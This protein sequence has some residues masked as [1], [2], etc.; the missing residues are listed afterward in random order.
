MERNI[1]AQWADKLAERITLRMVEAHYDNSLT[2]PDL[3]RAAFINK[4]ALGQI[5]T[6][7]EA[8]R[9]Q[10]ENGGYGGTGTK[11]S[12]RSDRDNRI[13]GARF[14]TPAGR[15]PPRSSGTPVRC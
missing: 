6:L 14:A 3:H 7:V 15:P 13:K 10:G 11:D 4:R 5:A 2:D 8:G 1:R 9:K 12:D